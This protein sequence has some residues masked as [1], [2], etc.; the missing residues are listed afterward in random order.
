MGRYD[1]FFDDDEYLRDRRGS[2]RRSSRRSSR[3]RSASGVAAL[4]GYGGDDDTRTERSSRKN[5]RRSSRDDDDVKEVTVEVFKTS[6]LGT[7]SKRPSKEALAPEHDSSPTERLEYDELLAIAHAPVSDTH[8][9]R[10][11]V[12]DTHTSI[13]ASSS[14]DMA[15]LRNEFKSVGKGLINKVLIDSIPEELDHVFKEVF[16]NTMGRYFELAGKFKDNYVDI[17]QT[18]HGENTPEI[19]EAISRLR[20]ELKNLVNSMTH[21][22]VSS[23][24]IYRF[25]T[26][27]NIFRNVSYAIEEELST[28]TSETELDRSSVT[29][30]MTTLSGNGNNSIIKTED[31]L[32]AVNGNKIKRI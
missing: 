9:T 13:Y 25:D 20:A 24:S 7:P 30:E 17:V 23:C 12:V 18:M 22:E 10:V 31:A 4:G 5:S 3:K 11:M 19:K 21:R 27:L 2:S 28:V 8:R 6:E 32:Y 15:Q 14:V 16:D 26:K 1:D 29:Y